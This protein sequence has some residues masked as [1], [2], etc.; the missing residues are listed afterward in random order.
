MMDFGPIGIEIK[1]VDHFGI[2]TGITRDLGIC[3]LVDEMIGVDTQ[4]ILTTGDVVLGMIINGLGFAS[5]PL[6]LTPQFFENKALDI[7]IKPGV[8]PNHFNRHKIGRTL[9]RISEFGCEK[10]FNQLALSACAK[11]GVNTQICHGD[12]TSYEL[13][14]HYDLGVD[15]N[16]EPI[17]EHRIK[18]THGYSKANRPD[19]KQIVQELITVEDGGIPLM[20]KTLSGNASDTTILKERVDALKTEFAKST[21]RI[22][23]ADSKLYAS[24][25]AQTLNRIYFITRVPATLNAEEGYVSQSLKNSDEWIKISDDY[26]YQEFAVK[27]LDIEDQRWVVYSSTPAYN[28]SKKTI[29]KE[30]IKEQASI[31]KEI[32]KLQNT[33]FGCES[34]ATHATHKATKKWRYHKTKTMSFQE[35]KK[36]EG[37]GRP[38]SET[39]YRFEYNITITFELDQE[40]V[41]ATLNHRSCFVLAANI[42]SL[43][44]AEI[45]TTYK[46]Q[47]HTEKAFAFLKKPEFFTAS[48]NLEKPGRIEAILTIMVLSLLVYSVAQRRLRKQLQATKQTLTN[49]LKKPTDRPTM[50][51]IF[52]QFE[53]V[54]LVKY[55]PFLAVEK[56]FI[57]GLTPLRKKI[58]SLLGPTVLNIYQTFFDGG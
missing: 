37:R 31:E 11:E 25:T 1:R 33:M 57:H 23:V 4:E 26:K 38:T 22:F 17:E 21:G 14:G 56:T 40:R 49:Q 28:R 30:I 55:T 18:I 35:I 8:E 47:D 5:R 24:T 41:D 34:D 2:I 53:G 52:Q 51:W 19:L 36:Y 45:L 43:T 3:E 6:M 16:G 9:D 27:E 7:L 42:S 46:G 44:A 29:E 13:H 15:E 48:L 12:T 50:R 54:D 39:P 10:F 58:I 32:N 20:T